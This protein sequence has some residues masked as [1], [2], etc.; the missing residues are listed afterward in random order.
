MNTTQNTYSN[1]QAVVRETKWKQSKIHTTPCRDAATATDKNRN[2]NLEIR[3][4]QN[5]TICCLYC[6]HK[7]SNEAGE[8]HS[9]GSRRARGLERECM[10]TFFE[11]IQRYGTSGLQQPCLCKV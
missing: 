3:Y 9:Y 1:L 7:Q 6:N 2:H 11:I 5:L 4:K 10:L 8:S